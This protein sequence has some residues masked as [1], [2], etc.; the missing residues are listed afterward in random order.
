MDVYLDF[1]FR[2]TDQGQAYEH[3]RAL[4]GAP[5]WV[6]T[7]SIR[8]VQLFA[9]SS[10]ELFRWNGRRRWRYSREIGE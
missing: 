1:D 4:I 8:A 10:T 3:D 6:R 5:L 2:D 7:P 9:E